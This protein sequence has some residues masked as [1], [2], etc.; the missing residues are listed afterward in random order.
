M[1]LT[2][3]TGIGFNNIDSSV[4]YN[5]EFYLRRARNCLS[6]VCQMSVKI[7]CILDGV[8]KCY[9]FDLLSS[10]S[11]KIAETLLETIFKQQKPQ[12]N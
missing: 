5:F 12:L 1:I 11:S 10:Y 3:D 9:I 4:W 2:H 7:W 8:D 6:N